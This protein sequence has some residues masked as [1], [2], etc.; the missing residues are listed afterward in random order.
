LIVKAGKGRIQ[1][2]VEERDTN[3]EHPSIYITINSGD[4][5]II[6]T[7]KGNHISDEHIIAVFITRINFS[8]V[9]YF[10]HYF[11]YKKTNHF[12]Q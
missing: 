11:M 12:K 7:K 8:K 4:F 9:R 3:L 1:V 5:S 2:R 10:C 6:I